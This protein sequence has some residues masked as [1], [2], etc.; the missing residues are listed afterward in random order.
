[1]IMKQRLL[2]VTLSLILFVSSTVIISTQTYASSIPTD[3]AGHWSE[4]FVTSLV[5]QGVIS[6]YPDGTFK[7]DKAIS[8]SELLSLILKAIG[9]TPNT[10]QGGESWNAPI[11][12]SAIQKGIVKSTDEFAQSNRELTREELA[13]ILYNTLSN[14]E[15]FK[16]DPSYTYIYDQGIL[17]HQSIDP[18]YRDAVYSMMQKGILTDN[19]NYFYP[20]QTASRGA[21]CVVIERIMDKGKRVDP[22]AIFEKNIIIYSDRFYPKVSDTAQQVPFLNGKPIIDENQTI[23]E[24]LNAPNNVGCRM[25]NDFYFYDDF[26]TIAPWVGDETREEKQKYADDLYD[27]TVE[28]MK[29]LFN[30]SYLDD[31]VAYDKA[32]RY[33]LNESYGSD[34][35]V[36]AKCEEIKNDTLIMESYFIT[37]KSLFYSAS[38]ETNRTRG[39][40]YL[41]I[42][43][44]SQNMTIGTKQGNWKNQVTLKKDQWYYADVEAKMGQFSKNIGLDW[45]VSKYTFDQIYYITNFI[46]LES[47]N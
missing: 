31:L 16:Y 20:K 22:Y 14:K 1:M 9:E 45:D 3:I 19:E 4:V 15:G 46:P 32:A 10:P 29:I 47:L 26:I 6:G 28:S 40:L 39:R 30:Y 13:Y 17:D 33:Y 8:S 7:P 41:V 42:K 23:Y 5:N 37:D 44:P 18:K 2:T 25:L 24:L 38:D 21:T 36:K 34:G 27:A 12:K 35:Y 43:S 11:I